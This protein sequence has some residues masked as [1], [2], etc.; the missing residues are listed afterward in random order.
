MFRDILELVWEYLRKTI[1]SRIFILG[2][3]Y[4]GMIGILVLRLYDL[5]I[6]NGQKYQEDYVQLAEKTVSLPATRGNIYDRNG[7]LLAYNKLAYAVEIQDNG[8]Y[9]SVY[10]RNYMLYR[11]V[12]ILH[13][14]EEKVIGNLM[15]DM[16]DQGNY[17][18]TTTSEAARRRFLRDFYGAKDVS[19]LDDASGNYPSDVDANTLIERKAKTYALDQLADED[20]I[21]V[22]LTRQELLDLVNIRYTMGFT[23]Y[24]KYESTK[25]ATDI[26]PETKTH[27][28]ENTSELMGV[29]I[30]EESL[31]VY[32]ESVYF[33]SIIGY[34]GKVQEDQLEDL[35]QINPNI[36]S[37]DMVGRIGIEQ[38]LEKDLHGIGG[39]MTIYTDKV[40]HIREVTERIDPIAGKDGYLTIDYDLQ[41]GVY[42]QLEQGLAGILA[43]KLS[44]LDEPN[45]ENTDSTD[46][47][48]PIKDAYFQLIHNNV[49]NLSRFQSA[50]ASPTEQ[51][52]YA[53]FQAYQDSVLASLRNE[54]FSKAPTPVKDLPEDQRAYMYY[55]YNM[56]SKEEFG[57]IKTDMMDVNAD[58]Y[59]RW[60]QDNIS[61]RE[62]FYTGISDGWIDTTLIGGDGKYS[63][64]DSIFESLVDFSIASLRFDLE[65]EKLN[66]KYMIRSNLI[67]GNELCIAL[68]DQGVLE[69]NP[70]EV[71]KLSVQGPAYA[72]SFLIQKIIEIE[73]TP[74]QLALDPCTAGAV[75]TDVNT[76]EVRALVSYPGYDANR[77]SNTMDVKYFNQLLQ[78]QSLP[79]Y[80]NATQARKAP[81]STFKPIAAIAALEQNVVSPL[82]LI[83]CTGEYTT[84]SPSIKCWVYPGKHNKLNVEGAIQHSCNYFFAELGHRLSTRPTGEYSASLGTEQLTKYATLF[85]LDHKS[86]VE[87]P[88]IDPTISD[89]SPEQSTMGQGHHQFANVQ[90]SRYVA[91]LANHGKV[92]ELSLVD[93]V[94]DDQGHTITDYT[95]VMSSEIHLQESTWQTVYSGMR[96]VIEAGSASR[97]FRDLEVNIAGKTGTAQETASRANHAFFI[98]YG[99]FEH[100]EVSVTVNI[101][102]GYSSS[103]AAMAA[104]D[105]YRLYFGYTNLDEVMSRKAVNVTKIRIG[106]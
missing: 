40:G 82:E 80:N 37:N 78:D 102:F 73:I 77:L 95:P 52:I 36:T 8:E 17:Y 93:K 56:L 45:K 42:H 7:R 19:Q 6:L 46:R 87:I 49:L 99:P 21:L 88:E 75:V 62:M 27:I 68:Y 12:K 28:L 74:A 94:V 103:N 18:Y 22:E 13:R 54:L 15:V 83:D 84:I 67:G 63:D 32:N 11:L 2:V 4:T 60:K 98:S 70:E 58:Y 24:K 89:I 10:A 81:G 31:R 33:S 35:K 20:G 101:P 1:M 65:F 79:L 38:F 43:S 72:Y 29:H 76:G 90:L 14:H 55:L 16:D 69:Y 66:Y 105:I 61:L 104:K 48:I 39:K 91:A 23:A 59:L 9:A 64:A 71:E 50:E 51:A 34:T 85:G 41:K 96:Q 3:I 97:I 44:P 47:M 53:K 26:K 106:D 30:A 86:G 5:Q 92:F 25:V 100:P 57:I